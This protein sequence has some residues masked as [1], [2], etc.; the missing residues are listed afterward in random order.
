MSRIPKTFVFID[1]ENI[2]MRYQAMIAEGRVA[3][4]KVKHVKDTFVW[5]PEITR[6][7]MMDIVRLN[8]YTSATGDAMRLGALRREIANV[9]YEYDFS[10]EKHVSAASGQIV[11]KLFHKVTQSRKT[12]NVDI[13]IIIDV[14]RT[15]NLRDCE[16]L[17]IV[18]GDGDYLPLIEEVGRLGKQVYLS[19][20]SSGLNDRLVSSVDTYCELDDFF[21]E[22]PSDKKTQA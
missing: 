1:G 19:A 5:H 13:N 16:T 14:M 20:F 17:Y 6:W 12:R 22:K 15:S 3:K 11:P 18:S 21:F 8:Y 2:T 10:T 9:F 7:T 4:R